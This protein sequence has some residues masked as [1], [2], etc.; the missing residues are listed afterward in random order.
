MKKTGI[1]QFPGS[2][3]DRDVFKAVKN[4]YPEFL[5]SSQSIEIKNYRAFIVPGG[6]SYGDYLRAG[7][8]AAKSPA[9]RDLIPAARKGWP[10][11][12]I[13]NGFQVLCEAGLLEGALLNNKQGRFIDE[14][15]DL[16]LENHNSF[17]PVDSEI[18]LP[19]AHGEGCYFISDEGLKS[20]KDN[21]QI[22]IKYRNN[23]NGSLENIA[24]VM[25][26]KGNVAALMP[27]PE[28]AMA[29]W[30]GGADGCSFFEKL[31]DFH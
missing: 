4:F 7:A 23:P 14:W 18:K 21:K 26:K 11:L 27:H 5:P 20:L 9:M 31:A 19:I 3:C 10:I 22:W 15:S 16:Q 24:G 12:G 28:R 25:N 13:C 2:N 30:M 8:L 29:K 6:F 17:W 1:L